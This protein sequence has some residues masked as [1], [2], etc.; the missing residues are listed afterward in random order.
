MPLK[1]INQLMPNSQQTD[2]LKKSN[3]P[4]M[5]LS[6][7]QRKFRKLRRDPKLFLADSKAYITTRKTL[8]QTWA[9]LG[10][11]A[12]V[13]LA[14]IIVVIYF[15]LMASPR[16]VSQTQFIVKQSGSNELPLLGLAAIG[17]ASPSMRDALI[18]QEY[19]QSPEMALAL[20]NKLYLK[21]HYQN[22]QWDLVSRLNNQSTK[23]DFIQY[24]Q[25]HLKIQYNELSEIL[26]VEIQGYTPDYALKLTQSLLIIS[27]QFIN[28][29]GEKMAKQQMQYAEEEV[30]RAYD[31]L[32]KEQ[33][34]L[35]NFQDK[36]KLYNPEQ[37]SSALL[38]A[39]NQ[40]ASQ[41]MTKQAELKS[42]N[43]Y[44]RNDASEIIAKKYQIEALEQQLQQEKH[45][46]IQPNQPSLNK[47]NLD[48][49]E[50]ELNTRLATDLYQSSLASLE[51]IRT[52]SFK[53]LKHLLVVEQ[54]RIAQDSLYPKRLYNI[55]TWFVVLLLIYLVG[56]LIIAIVKDHRE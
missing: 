19:I 31:K 38:S 40:L 9:K 36:S 10:S 20:D 53:K 47:V 4:P 7:A 42:L 28:Q 45:K 29:L 44:M 5:V 26:T 41:I 46:L 32:K 27:E 3:H 55:M 39:M 37:Q 51:R 11:F 13:I 22:S 12:L 33:I 17:T 50:I 30:N 48:F 34:K 56:R 15:S 8:Y 49:K 14:S 54:P 24:Y 18:L 2:A 21:R 16:Y 1:S 52:E 23:E 43:A 6:P 25:D 35:I